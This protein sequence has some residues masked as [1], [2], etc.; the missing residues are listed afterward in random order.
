MLAQLNHPGIAR[1][2]DSGSL[3]DATPWFVMEYVSGIPLT[4]YW[5]KRRGSVE[6]CLRLFRRVCD[7]VQHAHDHAIIHRDL[8]PSNILVTETGEVKL[9]DFGIAKQ[10]D[11]DAGPEKPTVAPLAMMTP[12]YCAP[13]QENGAPVGV[14]TDI[15]TLG[16][17]L[18]ELLTGHLPF[19]NEAGKSDET[20]QHKKEGDPLRP[21]SAAQLRLSGSG[22]RLSK[23]EWADLDAICRK[24]LQPQPTKRYRSVDG[25]IRDVD[26]FL[27]RRPLE[28][29]P[30]GFMYEL[31]KFVQR[32]RTWLIAAIALVLLA[33]AAGVFYTARL[34]RARNAALAEASRTRRIQRFMLELLGN[35]DAEAG[36]SNDLKVVT[37]L[38]RGIEEASALDADTE[39]QAQLYLTLGSMYNR[40]AQF[41]KADGLLNLALQKMTQATGPESAEVAG[42]LV[43]LATLRGD[44]GRVKEA[45]TY[46]ERALSLS[47]MRHL[48]AGDP[49]VV[50]ATVAKGRLLIQSGLYQQAIDI[51]TPITRIKPPYGED[52][53]FNIRDSLSALAVA[54]IGAQHFDIARDV[55]LRAVAMDRQLLG[56][57]HLQTGV[58]LVNLASVYASTRDYPA[59]EKL[60]R[61]GIAIMS[62]WSGPDNPDVL[63]AMSIL[64]KTLM[65]ENKDA[66]A[67]PIL[68]HVLQA[69]E[70]SYG[71]VHERV[72]YTLNA[73]GQISTRR[74]NFPEAEA[75][76]SRAATI[77]RLV[78]G[79]KNIRTAECISNLG[80]VYLKESRNELAE[81]T[82]QDAVEVLATLPPGNGLIGVAR[83]RWGRSLL[84]LHRYPE[85]EKQLT[86]AYQELKAQPHP[87]LTELQNVNE[88]L[89]KYHDLTNRP[90]KA[91]VFKAQL[92]SSAVSPSR[93]P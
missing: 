93:A 20:R 66:Q 44:E 6:E 47:T 22:P 90:G 42:V 56:N 34:A 72:A 43:Q 17:I 71:R 49:I 4:E 85:A 69:Q 63:T 30:D 50:T 15:Y 46:L 60:Y 52:Q 19:V 87:P 9:L 92:A 80:N 82:L 61:E 74:E 33:T 73:L 91:T 88:D 79:D 75:Y 64:A 67:E 68:K 1:I 39:T 59:A 12:D 54:E 23:A 29:R 58:D 26:A 55:S 89:A 13:E 57:S 28:A 2:Y 35:T 10:I 40:L 81:N 41:K 53:V 32:N 37:L 78:L 25:L 83:G 84:A 62:A 14:Y 36:P 5:T 11:V 70:Q 8:K 76:F 18:Y 51:L 3:E 21:S 77:Y 48:S 16:V 24:A 27:E 7:A 38:D 65:A 86:S 45:Q 31:G